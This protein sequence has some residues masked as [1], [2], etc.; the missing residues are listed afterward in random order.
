M[1]DPLSQIVFY[2]L[3]VL[4]EVLAVHNEELV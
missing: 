2:F 1:L 3:K 4:A